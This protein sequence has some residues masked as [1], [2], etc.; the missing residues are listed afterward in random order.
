MVIAEQ[1]YFHRSSQAVG[2]SIVDYLV[3]L[4][5]LTTYCEFGDYL[6][7]ALRDR[8]VCG[9]QR[10]SIQK[11]LLAE[12]DLTLVTAVKL[13]QSMGAAEKNSRALKDTVSLVQQFSAGTKLTT[14]QKK[15]ACYCC[16][17]TFHDQET[18]DFGEKTVIIVESEDT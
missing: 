3:E 7:Q 15:K 1:F 11:R 8:L 4:R 17:Q 10:E 6:E 13:V 2:E 12:V 14:V 5:R 16:G 9:I 18:V